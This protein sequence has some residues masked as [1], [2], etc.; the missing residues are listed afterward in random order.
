MTTWWTNFVIGEYLASVK[1]G[2][3]GKATQHLQ[4]VIF[5]NTSMKSKITATGSR[6][7]L[8]M[9]LWLILETPAAPLSSDCLF[10][11]FF[12]DGG[13]RKSDQISSLKHFERVK[14][15]SAASVVPWFSFG[16]ALF[17]HGVYT[18]ISFV[19]LLPADGEWAEQCLFLFRLLNG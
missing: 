18:V 9:A 13:K 10:V 1:D 4:V 11:C 6:M 12:S 19:P 17:H 7:W 8:L 3:R 5:T 16:G 2:S 14:S 15:P